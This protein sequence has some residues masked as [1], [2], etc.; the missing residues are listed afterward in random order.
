MVMLSSKSKCPLTVTVPPRRDEPCCSG[1]HRP[2]CRALPA[3]S[4]SHPRVES[5]PLPAGT[6][7]SR[8]PRPATTLRRHH[9]GAARRA[10]ARNDDDDDD[11]VAP[12]WPRSKQCTWEP[13]ERGEDAEQG[14]TTARGRRGSCRGGNPGPRR[15]PRG[16]LEAA[17]TRA[18]DGGR[19]DRPREGGAQR[20]GEPPAGGTARSGCR[21]GEPVGGC[22]RP[23]ASRRA[24]ACA[25]TYGGSCETV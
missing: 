15:R 12:P 14:R 17:A 18:T 21:T 20:R 7:V 22:G 1:V 5:A 4:T 25:S 9:S 19:T 8:T 6:G 16:N 2:A 24:A 3:F 10:R 23:P 11:D 13:R